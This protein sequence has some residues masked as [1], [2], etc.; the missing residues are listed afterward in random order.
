[1]ADLAPLRFCRASYLVNWSI[2]VTFVH[3]GSYLLDTILNDTFNDALSR[4]RWIGILNL[5]IDTP[6]LGQLCMIGDV[7]ISQSNKIYKS[8]LN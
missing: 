4:K 3:V 2:T 5:S 8:I 7:L 1:M 6:V